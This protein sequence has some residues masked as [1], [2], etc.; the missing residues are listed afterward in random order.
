[1]GPPPR[2]TSKGLAVDLMYIFGRLEQ[3][4]DMHDMKEIYKY[5]KSAAFLLLRPPAAMANL[6]R[7]SLLCRL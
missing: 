6:W 2:P 1:M 7:A 5:K 4:H 3:L